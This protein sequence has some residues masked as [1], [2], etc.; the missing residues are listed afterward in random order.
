MAKTIRLVGQFGKSAHMNGLRRYL[1]DAVAAITCI[2]NLVR[3][4]MGR[5]NRR[6]ASQDSLL[7]HGAS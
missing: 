5:P 4:A 3:C 7:R 2:L 1:R 6:R